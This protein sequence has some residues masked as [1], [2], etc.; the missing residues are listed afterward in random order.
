MGFAVRTRFILGIIGF[1]VVLLLI[2]ALLSLSLDPV[3]YNLQIKGLSYINP[4]YLRA[5]VMPIGGV[6]LSKLKVPYDPFIKSYTI[7]YLGKGIALLSVKER[8]ICCVLYANGEYVLISQDGYFLLKIPSSELYKA[9]GYKIFFDVGSENFNDY[10]IINTSIVR[11]ISVVLSYPLW[12]KK[13]VLEVDLMKKTLYFTRG[14][15][16]KV[17][18]FDLSNSTEEVIL[19]LVGDSRIGSR[20]LQIGNNFVHL[21]NS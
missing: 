18:K 2:K 9:T 15:S 6:H 11:D 17:Q 7:K 1:I 20:Y 8:K 4:S 19:K 16:V 12:F 10:R 21:P 14:I 3:V 5:S 13:E